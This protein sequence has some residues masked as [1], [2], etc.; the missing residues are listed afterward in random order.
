VGVQNAHQVRGRD[1]WRD[2]VRAG[3]L[4]LTQAFAQLRFDVLQPEGFVDLGFDSRRD[5]LAPATQPLGCESHAPIRR[6][7]LQPFEVL[8]RP[9]CKE[10]ADAEA[11]RV[12]Q[13]DRHLAGGDYLGWAG[14]PFDLRDQSQV[15]NELAAA[16][17][18][19]GS[20]RADQAGHGTPQC[21][22]SREGQFV[23]AMQVA[24]AQCGL[25][26][27]QAFEDLALHRGSEP[28][29]LLEP[30]LARRGLESSE[31]GNAE[32]LVED[33]DLLRLQPGD[34]EHVEHAF[35]YV[36]AQF[37]QQRMGAGV[38]QLGH[39]VG[40]RLANSGELAKPVLRDD[41]VEGFDERRERV[42]GAQ[43]GFGTEVIVAGERRAAA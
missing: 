42:R 40:N 6:P 8:S 3:A 15:R 24:G 23:G 27:L 43:V 39:D 9:G 19:A 36:P 32:F 35:R 21:F 26:D 14:E 7:L 37:F 28:L 33:V 29:H 12:S 16:A 4:D 5:D 10:Q 17:E 30:V 22:G 25:A 1:Q 13:I 34:R 31:V 41:A 2:L 38:V 18:V 11:A 20:N